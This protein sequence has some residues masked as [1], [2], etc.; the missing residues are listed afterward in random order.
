[1]NRVPA[2]PSRQD[3]PGRAPVRRYLSFTLLG[4]LAAFAFAV[5]LVNFILLPWHVNMGREATVPDVLGMTRDEAERT[6]KTQGFA[7]GDARYVAD[8]QY[9][10][11]KVVDTRPRVGTR[12]KVGRVVGLDISAGREMTQVPA[13]ARL[14]VRRAQA[15]IENAGL[16]VGEIEMVVSLRVPEGEV[17]ATSPTANERLNKGTAVNLTV[18]MGAQG[19]VEMPRLKGL[20]L[21]RARDIIINN[22]LT[23]A[24]TVS[25]VSAEPT[26]TVIGQSPGEGNEVQSGA[27]VKLTIAR[28]SDSGSVAPKPRKPAQPKTDKTP[29][30]TKKPPAAKPKTK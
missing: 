15:A 25:T 8:T 13:V 6:L 24:E 14:P 11:G 27:A 21:S 16:R 3:S 28:H 23:L 9:A 29:N 5:L 2:E 4:M 1:M 26:G 18:S 17:I 19:M 7:A 20:T 30:G 22:G 12:V 10:A